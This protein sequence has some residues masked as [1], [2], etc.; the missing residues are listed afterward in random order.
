M[1]R[2]SMAIEMVGSDKPWRVLVVDDDERVL[3]VLSRALR[4]LGDGY[5]VETAQSGKEALRKAIARPYD[6]VITDIVMLDMDG[7]ELARAIK[8][9]HADTVVIWIT[10]YSRHR[11]QSDRRRLHVYRCLEKPL[12]VVEIR[13]AVLDA[14]GHAESSKGAAN[15]SDLGGAT[16]SLMENG[17]MSY[18]SG[19]GNGRA[20]R[21]RASESTYL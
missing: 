6:I 9:L 15:D 5:R 2:H 11:F 12:G 7:I 8:N 20:G 10:A 16:A 17:S 21:E 1:G 18:G 3:F 14:A 19:G 4:A 13:Q